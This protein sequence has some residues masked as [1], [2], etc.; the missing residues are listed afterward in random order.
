MCG[1]LGKRGRG[2][3]CAFVVEVWTAAP[4]DSGDVVV[5]YFARDR[6]HRDI[7]SVMVLH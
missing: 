2:N 4:K 5:K 6:I 1:M 7:N 3:L